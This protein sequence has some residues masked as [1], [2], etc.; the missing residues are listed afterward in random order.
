MIVIT[1][2]KYIRVDSDDVYALFKNKSMY[3]SVLLNTDEGQQYR[4]VESV[5]EFIK[6]R[7]FTTPNGETLVVGVSDEVGKLLGIHAEAWKSLEADVEYWRN[8]VK[9]QDKEILTCKNSL[10]TVNN[11]SRWE[12]IKWVFTGVKY[13]T[14]G[15]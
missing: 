6:G 7:R 5:I 11:A 15:K 2:I 9:K 4:T 3:D 8:T 14:N 12:R 1:D 10:H 13:K